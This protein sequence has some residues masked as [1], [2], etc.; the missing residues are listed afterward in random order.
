MAFSGSGISLP[1]ESVRC[2]AGGASRPSELLREYPAKG[3]GGLMSSRGVTRPLS[4]FRGSW[5]SLPGLLSR[6][7]D[8]RDA[9][10]S[11]G[12]AWCARPDSTSATGTRFSTTRSFCHDLERERECS[13][14]FGRRGR[15]V[16]QPLTALTPA[17]EPSLENHDLLRRRRS[18]LRP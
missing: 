5:G 4:G 16:T 6:V 2:G 8:V 11:D 14:D 12:G 18:V 1:R 15:V 3:G 9:V 13:R 7:R 10:C 17:P